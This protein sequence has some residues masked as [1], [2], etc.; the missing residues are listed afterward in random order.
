M[1]E[2]TTHETIHWLDRIRQRIFASRNHDR[3]ALASQPI[4][5]IERQTTVEMLETTTTTG[6]FNQQQQQ[7]SDDIGNGV[8]N[9]VINSGMNSLVTTQFSEENLREPLLG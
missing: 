2:A 4:I 8:S 3:Q 9:N 6:I 7:E 5:N 1:I